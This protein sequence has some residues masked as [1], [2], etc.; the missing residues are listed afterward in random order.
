MWR[1][2]ITFVCCNQIVKKTVTKETNG[3]HWILFLLVPGGT[4]V[5]VRLQRKTLVILMVALVLFTRVAET[6]GTASF[7]R[8]RGIG[9]AALVARCGGRSKGC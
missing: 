1:T 4:L 6:W 3:L 9:S 5:L 7:C 2:T 8:C